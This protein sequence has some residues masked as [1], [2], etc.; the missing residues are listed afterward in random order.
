MAMGVPVVVSD[1]KIDRQYFD[2]SIVRFFRG[3]DE[4]DLAH[5]ILDLIRHREMRQA[6]IERATEFVARNDW[7]Q[8]KHEYLNLVDE[9]LPVNRS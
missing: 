2:D 6:L 7:A 8:K 4:N 1:T 9:L 3:E 5:A